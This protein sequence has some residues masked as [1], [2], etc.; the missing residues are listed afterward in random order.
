MKKR[1]LLLLLTLVLAALLLAQKKAAPGPDPLV[2]AAD[3]HKLVFENKLV[4]V[5]ETKI[6]AGK[7]E[8][9]HGHPHGVTV[10]LKDFEVRITEDG[11]PPVTRQRKGGTA[12]WSEATVHEV[13]NVGK[14]DGHVFRI[15]LKM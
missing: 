12:V 13:V 7:N 5:I 9:R 11:K 8:P 1:I 3:T 14:T 2:V 10:Y 15:E 4:R 6:P